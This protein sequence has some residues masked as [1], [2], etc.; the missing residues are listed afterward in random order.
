[1]EQSLRCIVVDD[2]PTIRLAL[3][4]ILSK[5]GHQVIAESGS[6]AEGLKLILNM[7]PDIVLLDINLPD[8]DGLTLLDLLGSYQLS[9][10]I[11]VL[12]EVDNVHLAARVR[13]MGGRGY[14]HK[15]ESLDQLSMVIQLVSSG[16]SYFSDKVVAI[17][18][19]HYQDNMAGSILNSLS[20]REL[21][22][23]RH[24]VKGYSNK[25][26]SE[27]MSLSP[28]TVS[29]YRTRMFEKLGINTLAELVEIVNRES[30]PDKLSRDG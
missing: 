6:G 1:M 28:K 12:S 11:I 29:T 22:V 13:A 2:H 9:S 17:G 15:S 24:L 25:E 7:E 21:T 3:Q 23:L 19:K 30:D 4:L 20:Q 16:Y 5:A 8:M 26:I 10:R 14:L 18:D 27:K